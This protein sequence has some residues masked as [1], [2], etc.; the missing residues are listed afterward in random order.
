MSPSINIYTIARYGS[1]YILHGRISEGAPEHV[2]Y[3]NGPFPG[4]PG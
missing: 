2:L 3:G 4:K 1:R